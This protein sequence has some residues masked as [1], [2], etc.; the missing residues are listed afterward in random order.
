MIKCNLIKAT[1][2]R[3]KAYYVTIKEMFAFLALS[4]LSDDIAVFTENVD[5]TH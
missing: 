3:P 1:F 5:I 4:F 2:S